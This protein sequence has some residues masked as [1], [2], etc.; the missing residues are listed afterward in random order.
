MIRVSSKFYQVMVLVLAAVLLMFSPLLAGGKTAH[1]VM[2]ME[3]LGLSLLFVLVWRNFCRNRVSRP[4]WLF[5]ILSLLSVCIYLLPL[6]ENLWLMLP[7]RSDYVEAILWLERTGREEVYRS[8]ALLPLHGVSFLLACIPPLAVFLAV[9]SVSE[10]GRWLLVNVFL[11]TAVFQSVLA[12]T[13]YFGLGES[14]SSSPLGTYINQNHLT[15]FME[16]AEPLALALMLYALINHQLSAST[17]VFQ[18]IFYAVISLALT[19]IP[20]ISS[21]RMGV[22]LLLVSVFLS[23][24]VMTTRGIRTRVMAPIVALRLALLALVVMVQFN[25]IRSSA[26]HAT[27]IVGGMEPETALGDLRWELWGTSLEIT[28]DFAPFGVGISSVPQVYQRYQS[29]TLLKFVNHLHNDYL[30]LVAELGVVG[31]VI[32]LA[33]LVLYV[34]QWFLLKYEHSEQQRLIQS[35]A[36]V[37]ILLF[38]LFSLTEYNLHTPANVLFLAFLCGLF[39]VPRH[40]SEQ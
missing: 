17:R 8:L 37:G 40:T 23:F 30:E 19:F 6:P 32:I 28:N 11:L 20:L 5:I 4:V 27:N 2:V 29:D 18:A 34:R 14:T 22:A 13:Q 36:G 21:S 7:G 39:F 10:N 1:A 25:I 9:R 31:L 3:L 35:G 26:G 12:M 16:M 15:A 33:F 24:W 38:L